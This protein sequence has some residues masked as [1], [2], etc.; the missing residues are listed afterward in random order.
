MP[1][2][3]VVVPGAGR[4][5]QIHLVARFAIS[6]NGGGNLIDRTVI[7]LTRRIPLMFQMMHGSHGRSGRR[8]RYQ[9][10]AEHRQGG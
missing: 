8:N 1:I 6:D 7:V 3:L 9:D 2:T 10:H 4:T 5:I